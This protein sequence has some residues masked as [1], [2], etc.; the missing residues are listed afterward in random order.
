MIHLS[1]QYAFSKEAYPY[2]DLAGWHRSLV[3]IYGAESLMWATDFPW[4]FNN[5]GYG[6]MARI[7]DE[8]LPELSEH[9]HTQIM[10]GNA[11][12]FLRFPDC[13]N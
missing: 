12:R 1:G 9:E 8:L 2:R 7:I 13:Q 3:G 4:I 5:P 11:K 6:K 10:G